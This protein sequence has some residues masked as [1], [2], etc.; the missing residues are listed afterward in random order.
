VASKLSLSPKSIPWRWSIRGAA[1]LFFLPYFGGCEGADQAPTPPIV[2]D[3]A[4][5]EIVVNQGP[6]WARGERWRLSRKPVVSLGDA[7]NDDRYQFGYVSDT[8]RFPDG[9]IAVVDNQTDEVK[10]YDPNGVYL[11]NLSRRG[12]GPGEFQGPGRLRGYRGDSIL[13]SDGGGYLFFDSEEVFGRVMRG[14]QVLMVWPMED[15]APASPGWAMEDVF[16]DGSLLIQ[17]TQVIRTSGSGMRRGM[18]TLVRLSPDGTE[19]DTIT[20]YP[21][22]RYF[23]R[24]GRP[25]PF[26][27]H[28]G[29]T[30]S[31][32]LHDDELFIG[33]GE[34]FRIDVLDADGT[35][36]RSIRVDGPSPPLTEHLKESYEEFE[37]GRAGSSPEVPSSMLEYI[38]SLPYPEH[39]PAYH[40]ILADELGNLWVGHWP[41]DEYSIHPDLYTVFDRSG[42]ML[43]TVDFPW[44]FHARQIGAD[45]V[46]GTWRDEYDVHHVQLYDLVKPG[47]SQ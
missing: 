10:L 36:T 32:A 3:S 38:L 39:L 12:E 23:P 5:V 26:Q 29:L 20:V 40:R 4:G 19:V 1:L 6:T 41:E 47:G 35:L 45:F 8:H 17:Y 18:V 24:R 22:G 44:G 9:R 11:H 7:E 31:A 43:G 28:F 27:E 42:V 34:E 37:G 30:V 14:F 25:L 33:N 13:I 21:G 15:R 46:L 16:S 2:T